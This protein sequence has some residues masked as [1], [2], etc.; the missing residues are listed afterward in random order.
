MKKLSVL[1]AGTA[2]VHD[3]DALDGG[4][5]RFVG[6]KHDPSLGK[7]GGWVPS[8]EPVEIPYRAEYIQELKAGAL[9]PADEATAKAAGLPFQNSKPAS[10]DKG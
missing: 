7:N 2:L 3:L 10:K 9:L 8:N 1:A 5:L 6:R 4:V